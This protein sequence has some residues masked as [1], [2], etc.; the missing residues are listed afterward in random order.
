MKA[1]KRHCEC[2]VAS[3]RVTCHPKHIF[4]EV[5]HSL[6]CRMNID[7][8]LVSIED[9]EILASPMPMARG[10]EYPGNADAVSG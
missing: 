6:F 4:N 8:R 1:E 10:V 7:M 2:L 3:G 5:C 9:F